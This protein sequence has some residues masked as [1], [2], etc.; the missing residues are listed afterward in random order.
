MS[1]L[2]A[3]VLP[4]LKAFVAGA[5]GAATVAVEE[6]VKSGGFTEA[7]LIKVAGAAVLAYFVTWIS[8]NKP[9]P[10]DPKQGA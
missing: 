5:V 9:A 1:K 6:A 10:A 3:L 7:S 4:R 2:K 8:P